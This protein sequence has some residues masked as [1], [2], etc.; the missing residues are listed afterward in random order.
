MNTTTRITFGAAF[1]LSTLAAC[2]SDSPTAPTPRARVVP[3]GVLRSGWATLDSLNAGEEA[4]LPETPNKNRRIVLAEI[5]A[6]SSAA[7]TR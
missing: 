5:S 2:T 4:E 6:T 7:L 3:Q 1:L